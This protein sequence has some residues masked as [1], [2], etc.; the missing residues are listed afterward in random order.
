[1]MPPSEYIETRNGGH[2]IAGTRV[3][4]DVIAHEFRNGRSPEAIFEAYPSI[5]SLA[6]VYG[7]LTFILEHPRE[8][9]A[10][11][12]DQDRR[13]AEIKARFPLPPDMIERFERAKSERSATRE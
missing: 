4:L 13:Y 9:D 10:Y 6:R 12:E 11:L 5:G 1:M 2:Y 8:V 7:A 3:G